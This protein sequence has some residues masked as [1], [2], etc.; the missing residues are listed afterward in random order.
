MTLWKELRI[1]F[2]ALTLGGVLFVLVK[3]FMT[4]TINKPKP[5]QSQ[6]ESRNVALCQ[7]HICIAL[8]SDTN[9]NAFPPSYS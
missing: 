5:E 1:L 8:H 2:L 9:D 3:V 4:T 6:R 7:D